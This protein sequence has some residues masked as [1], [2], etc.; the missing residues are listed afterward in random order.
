MYRTKPSIGEYVDYLL[1]IGTWKSSSMPRE[2][3]DEMLRRLDWVRSEDDT[4]L[5][6]A[7]M[8]VPMAFLEE[9]PVD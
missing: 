8:R 4:E 2:A 9:V 5:C 7:N 6:T 3:L 1:N